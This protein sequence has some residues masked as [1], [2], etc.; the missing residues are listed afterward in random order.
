MQVLLAA[1]QPKGMSRLAAIAE[2]LRRRYEVSI[3]EPPTATRRFGRVAS[4]AIRYSS[5]I[6]KEAFSSADVLHAFNA[7]D[8]I[9]TVA[10]FKRARLCYD[11]RSNYSEKLGFSYPHL[12]PFARV[13][14]SALVRKATTLVTVNQVL[15][16]RLQRLTTKR[17]FVVPNYPNKSFRPRRGREKTRRLLELGDRSMA[18]FSGSLTFTYDFDLLFA[19]ATKLADVRFVIAGGGPYRRRLEAIAP[20]NVTFLGALPRREIPDI[21]AAS[22]VCLVPIRRYSLSTIHN[23]QDVWKITEAAAL[24]KSIVATGVLPSKQYYLASGLD[25]FVRGITLA[26]NSQ[27]PPP[28]P[29]FWEDFSEPALMDAYRTIE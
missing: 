5:Y 16:R 27:I 21:I 3:L 4:A 2:S 22:D 26:L 13:L 17:V 11:Y 25:D 8:F 12:A 18:L 1:Q 23:D 20:A 19:A 9:H 10:L 7:P 14:E 28:E 29:R 15:A 6:L 24:G